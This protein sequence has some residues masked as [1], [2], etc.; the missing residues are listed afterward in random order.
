VRE[1]L[2]LALGN[3]L[4]RFAW[5]D[6]LRVVFYRLAG[7]HIG[8]R[9]AIWRPVVVRPLDSAGRIHIG[10]GS[11]LN[12]Y[13]RFGARQ[14]T[15]TI[16]RNCQIGA[17]VCFETVGHTIEAVPGD[18]RPDLHGPISVEDEVWIGSGAIITRD[19]TIGRGAVVAAGAVVTR[20]VPPGAVVGGVPAR[21]LESSRQ[22]S[23]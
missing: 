9:C 23:D 17:F 2:C 8:R 20:D 16:G 4:P 11:F 3:L 6:R 15:V 13:V 22:A 19:V 18:K 7:M 1:I 10:E 21:P 12:S 14:A 5:G